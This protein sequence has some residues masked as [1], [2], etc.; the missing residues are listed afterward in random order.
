MYDNVYE[1]TIVCISNCRQ[2]LEAKVSTLKLHLS[3]EKIQMLSDFF[4]HIPV[5]HS[6]SMMGLDDSVDGHIEPVLYA[7][8]MVSGTLFITLFI[9][10]INANSRLTFSSIGAT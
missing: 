3:D 9:S 2:K 1:L 8:V 6:S 5:P 4:H 10:F 7:M